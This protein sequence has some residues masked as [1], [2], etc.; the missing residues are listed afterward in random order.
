VLEEG[1]GHGCFGYLGEECLVYSCGYVEMLCRLKNN[2]GRE[3]VGVAFEVA[4]SARR[5][6]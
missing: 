3:D 5:D 6:F 4:F 1:C 2:D